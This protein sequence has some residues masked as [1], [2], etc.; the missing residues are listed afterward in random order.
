MSVFTI[1]RNFVK[2]AETNSSEC[3]SVLNFFAKVVH[4]VLY[5]DVNR[6]LD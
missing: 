6:N 4:I 2:E 3:K 5:K 1:S